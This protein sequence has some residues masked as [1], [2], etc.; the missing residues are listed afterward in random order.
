[1]V[2]WAAIM[3]MLN[4]DGLP[5]SGCFE[6]SFHS[7]AVKPAMSG[8]GGVEGLGWCERFCS[9]LVKDD[10]VVHCVAHLRGSGLDG[11]ILVGFGLSF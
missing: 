1:M 7:R 8:G 9:T 3:S 4:E 11:E 10:P 6:W 5:Q 2:L